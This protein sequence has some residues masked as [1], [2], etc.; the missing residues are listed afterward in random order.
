MPFAADGRRGGAGW[1]E[2]FGFGTD[3][4][5]AVYKTREDIC[6]QWSITHRSRILVL[7]SHPVLSLQM[8]RVE[9]VMHSSALPPPSC[10]LCLQ[11][12]TAA[13]EQ[14][15]GACL[16]LGHNLILHTSARPAMENSFLCRLQ[17]SQ[18]LS[19]AALRDCKLILLQIR[20]HCR[21]HHPKC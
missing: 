6:P 3:T 19:G 18:V 15:W 1:G 11:S 5:L 17:V 13:P 12:V 14:Q 21:Q 20:C 9:M 10:L 2:S 16:C 7:R 8:H 4:A